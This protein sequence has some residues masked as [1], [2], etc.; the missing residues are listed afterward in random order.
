MHRIL[1]ET[2]LNVCIDSQPSTKGERTCA[3][4]DS[5]AAPNQANTMTQQSP[6]SNP[7]CSLLPFPARSILTRAAQ[8]PVTEDDPFARE[9]A[10]RE[11]TD[12]VRREYPQFFKAPGSSE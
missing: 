1:Q 9:R 12:R 7:T 10:I 4:A 8:T 2:T 11:A 6:G 3:S 5:T